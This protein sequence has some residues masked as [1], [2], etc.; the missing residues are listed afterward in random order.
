[1]EAGDAVVAQWQSAF[2]LPPFC[3]RERADGTG[4]PTDNR[5][6]AG[7]IPAGRVA[8]CFLWDHPPDR[9]DDARGPVAQR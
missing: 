3:P 2:P 5:E 6:A 1:M 8:G 7:S 9:A 4:L